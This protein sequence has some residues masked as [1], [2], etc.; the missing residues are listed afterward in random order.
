MTQAAQPT[1]TA[2][3]KDIRLI[4]VDIDGTLLNSQMELS[5]RNEKALKAAQEQGV[6]IAIA[7]GKTY[8]AAQYLFD[9]LGFKTPGIFVQGLLTYDAAG[10]ITHQQVLSPAVARQAITFAED[11]GFTLLVYSGARIL[12]RTRDEKLYAEMAKYHETLEPAGPLVNILNDMPVNKVVAIGADARA[13]KAL[14]WQLTSVLG[15]TARVMQAGIPNMLEVLPPGVSKGSALKMITKDMRIPADSVLAI[16]DAEND[17]EMLE[18][19]GI[20]VAMGQAEQAVKDKANYVAPTHDE[21]GVADAIEKFVLPILPPA[22]EVKP[23]AAPTASAVK[24]E[25]KPEP[26]AAATKADDAAAA[27]GAAKTGPSEPA[28]S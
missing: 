28:A 24:A 15:G 9:R 23:D 4:V 22:P 14:R 6:Q 10:T 26:P 13:I 20:G 5:A 25:A 27:D 7:T 16:G 18:F 17:I 3:R 21:D 1:L 19:A 11:R 2:E 8:G 12:T